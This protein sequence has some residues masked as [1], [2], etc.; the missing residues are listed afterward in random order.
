MVIEWDIIIVEMS[1]LAGIIY[2][3]VYLEHWTYNRSQKKEDEK[4]IQNLIKI[5]TIRLQLHPHTPRMR[6]MRLKC[7][8]HQK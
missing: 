7:L 6:L 1:I 5:M 8:K 2:F 3:S 4:I